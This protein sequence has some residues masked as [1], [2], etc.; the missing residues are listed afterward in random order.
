MEDVS[1]AAF[2]QGVEQSLPHFTGEDGVCQQLS[3]VLGEMQD[4]SHRWRDMLAS[5]CRTGGE[6]EKS[7]NILRL[8]AVQAS[9]FLDRDI[10]GPHEVEVQGAGDGRV[11]GSTR[12]LYT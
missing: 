10:V 4:V 6:F 2:V 9:Q 7:Q 8:E 12:R 3:T 5:G 11:D 1:L